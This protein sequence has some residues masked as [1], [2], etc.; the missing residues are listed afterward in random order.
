MPGYHTKAVVIADL[1]KSENPVIT[2]EENVRQLKTVEVRSNQKRVTRVKGNKGLV[3]GA[4]TESKG[5]YSIFGV[6]VKPPNDEALLESISFHVQNDSS[7]NFTVRPI[8]Y[9][10]VNDTIDF[11][12]NLLPRDTT[13]SF[14]AKSGWMK[15]DLSELQIEPE[16]KM[17]VGVHWL[18]IN[19]QKYGTK[20]SMSLISFGSSPSIQANGFKSFVRY[21]GIGAYAIKAAFSFYK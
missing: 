5:N 15:M 13:F 17:A 12:S 14:T 6:H 21:R 4:V 11:S 3:F 8:V 19:N 18:D 2:L 16:E 1:L 7:I 10:V 9:A 20:T